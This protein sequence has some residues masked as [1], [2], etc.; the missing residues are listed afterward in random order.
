MVERQSVLSCLVKIAI[1]NYANWAVNQANYM[2][3]KRINLEISYFVSNVV[4]IYKT[5]NEKH[6]LMKI[7]FTQK[8]IT[9]SNW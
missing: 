5:A 7:Q 9:A 8:P 6:F 3:L 1:C 2:Y 4:L